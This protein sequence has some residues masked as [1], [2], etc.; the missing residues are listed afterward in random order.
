MKEATQR[1]RVCDECGDLHTT[2]R[3]AYVNKKGN[4]CS[5]ECIAARRL[6]THGQDCQEC[7][8]RFV[9]TAKGSP[10]VYCSRECGK[11]AT[12]RK[13]T[14]DCIGCGASFINRHKNVYC[15]NQCRGNHQREQAARNCLFCGKSWYSP[16]TNAKPRNGKVRY[17]NAFCSKRCAK[18]HVKWEHDRKAQCQCGIKTGFRG[19]VCLDCK[20]S[21]SS[22]FGYL[23]E[24][25][26][27]IRAAFDRDQTAWERRVASA[28]QCLKKRLKPRRNKKHKKVTTWSEGIQK[29]RTA[30]QARVHRGQKNP[31]E[32]RV[33]AARHNLG[34]R[35][36]LRQEK[37]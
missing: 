34:V 2:H 7:G 33:I 3:N 16:R 22:R 27:G 14:R 17:H 30:L 35:A 13:H 26:K 10:Q 12:Q 23:G 6:K 1:K 5:T 21:Q 31:W 37:N 9:K 15:S 20:W 28:S 19:A 32:K 24:W 11:Q 25:A 4:F 8:S 36:R 18:Q 29:A